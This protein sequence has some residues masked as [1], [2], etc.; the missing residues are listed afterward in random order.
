MPNSAPG[1]NKNVF[2]PHGYS[3]NSILGGAVFDFVDCKVSQPFEYF[4]AFKNMFLR[5][6]RIGLRVGF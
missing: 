3:E 5:L 4:P 2:T 1:R 6:G